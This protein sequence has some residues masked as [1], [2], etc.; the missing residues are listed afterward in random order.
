MKKQVP[1][2]DDKTT[3]SCAMT[4]TFTVNVGG[5]RV[6]H[7]FS[8][9]KLVL[10]Y[11]HDMYAKYC[12]VAAI[13]L[14]VTL[15]SRSPAPYEAALDLVPG[16]RTVLYFTVLN[17][18]VQYSAVTRNPTGVPTRS[19]RVLR[20]VLELCRRDCRVKVDEGRLL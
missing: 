20:T 6:Q 13:H 10:V 17:W 16:C 9:T 15:G 12:L 14:H 18:S 5:R 1:R 8:I 7:R 4:R 2:R 19:S 11:T 3:V